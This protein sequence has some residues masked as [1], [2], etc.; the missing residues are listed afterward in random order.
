MADMY[1]LWNFR[2]QYL[3]LESCPNFV[4]HTRNSESLS[5]FSVSILTKNITTLSYMWKINK[6]IKAWLTVTS[7]YCGKVSNVVIIVP[8]PYYGVK[9]LVRVAWLWML[10]VAEFWQPD[11]MK[12]GVNWAHWI[13][14]TNPS[15]IHPQKNMKMQF[16]VCRFVDVWADLDN[17]PDSVMDT[18]NIDA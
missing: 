4:S 10:S 15:I 16:Q 1:S 5:L 2:F 11:S 7:W 14:N 13:P 12:S 8:K 9:W 17:V 6:F 18:V 3:V